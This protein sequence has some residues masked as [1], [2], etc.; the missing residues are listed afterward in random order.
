VSLQG[1]GNQG[2][3]CHPGDMVS[4]AM[5]ATPGSCVLPPFHG[6]APAAASAQ[7]A[8]TGAATAAAASSSRGAGPWT[9]HRPAA[10][11]LLLLLCWQ[12]PRAP[13]QQG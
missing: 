9:L 3:E 10:P 11:V 13:A 12:A 2:G 8:C 1:W 6:P 7:Q 5:M 4:L